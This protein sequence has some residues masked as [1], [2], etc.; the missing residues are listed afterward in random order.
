LAANGGSPS[1]LRSDAS[2]GGGLAGSA[3]N[4]LNRPVAGGSQLVAEAKVM[5]MLRSDPAAGAARVTSV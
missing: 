1:G 4:R 5:G 2:G 3:M